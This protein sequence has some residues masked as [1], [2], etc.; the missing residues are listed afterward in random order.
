MF[1]AMVYDQ[2]PALITAMEKG[3]PLVTAAII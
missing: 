1:S 2:T 3:P